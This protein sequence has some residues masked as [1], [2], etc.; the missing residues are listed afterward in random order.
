MSQL[1]KA[2]S[3]IIG[4]DGKHTENMNDDAMR[5]KGKTETGNGK[6]EPEKVKTKKT[7]EKKEK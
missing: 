6:P 2:G 3:Y 5:R 4:K 7:E 1:N